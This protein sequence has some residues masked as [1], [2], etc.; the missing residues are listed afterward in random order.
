M[1][2]CEVCAAT[3]LDCFRPK[4]RMSQLYSKKPNGLLYIAVLTF[5]KVSSGIENV[6]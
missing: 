6:S 2:N 1:K 3:K 5:D 4:A